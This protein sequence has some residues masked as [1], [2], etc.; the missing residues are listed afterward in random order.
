M[1]YLD[2][3]NPMKINIINNIETQNLTNLL[4][5]DISKIPTNLLSPIKDIFTMNYI[6]IGKEAIDNIRNNKKLRAKVKELG[7][8][9][10]LVAGEGALFITE[11]KDEKLKSMIKA[12]SNIGNLLFIPFK[13]LGI[14]IYS[15]LMTVCSGLPPCALAHRVLKTGTRFMKVSTKTLELVLRIGTGNLEEFNNMLQLIIE[16]FV[17]VPRSIQ[18]LVKIMNITKQVGKA[19]RGEDIE[20]DEDF[21][22]DNSSMFKNSALGNLSM[23]DTSADSDKNKDKKKDKKKKKKNKTKK[24]R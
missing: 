18:T 23:G 5:D 12:T 11:E 24:K 17:M 21:M 13:S 1:N 19:L 6:Q 22:G 3:I 7:Y 16:A 10:Y 4:G 8:E 14:V 9:L 20:V 2:A 15:L